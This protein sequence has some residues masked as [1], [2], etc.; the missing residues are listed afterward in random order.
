MVFAL[1]RVVQKSNKKC[2]PAIVKR[3][4][5]SQCGFGAPEKKYK[6]DCFLSPQRGGFNLEIKINGAIK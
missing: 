3:R 5:I 4:Y 6:C 2:T 1:E